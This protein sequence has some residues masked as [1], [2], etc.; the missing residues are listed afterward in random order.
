M[1]N[2]D[3]SLSMHRIL[4]VLTLLIV[5]TGTA[6]RADA[7]KTDNLSC[8]GKSAVVAD[9]QYQQQA[10]DVLESRHLEIARPLQ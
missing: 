9:R 3:R 6:M 5:T 7:T 4:C 8:D 2:R 10:G 1:A